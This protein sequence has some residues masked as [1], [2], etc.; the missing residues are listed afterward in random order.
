MWLPAS[1]LPNVAIAVKE[2]GESS[3]DQAGIKPKKNPLAG[4]L[5]EIAVKS[6]SNDTGRITDLIAKSWAVGREDFVNQLVPELQAA[7]DSL[8]GA[9]PPDQELLKSIAIT[10]KKEYGDIAWLKMRKLERIY[11]KYAI[12]DDGRMDTISRLVREVN[13]FWSVPEFRESKLSVFAPLFVMPDPDWLERGK[14]RCREYSQGMAIANAEKR[15]Y[16]QANES[17]PRH[18]EDACAAKCK[19]VREEFEHLLDRCKSRQERLQAVAA[20]WHSLHNCNSKDQHST[21]LAFLVGLPE[22]CE[23]LQELRITKLHIL[24][25]RWSD[26]PDAVFQ[27]ET[28]PLKLVPH[29]NNYLFAQDREGKFLGCLSVNDSPMFL[30]DV[31]FEAAIYTRF[32][33]K[34]QPM[35]NEVILLDKF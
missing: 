2:F 9:T 3:V 30:Q 1:K 20:I 35:Y 24:G 13:Q 21:S 32:D 7:V 14:L 33:K 17:V 26:Y 12:T 23:A 27:G 6:M 29:T 5:G 18:I 15:K 11:V 31:E 8:K 10:L 28:M 19:A 22:I 16:I 4:T 34:N 25:K